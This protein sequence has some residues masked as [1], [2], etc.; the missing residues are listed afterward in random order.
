MPSTEGGA[1]VIMAEVQTSAAEDQEGA[2][3]LANKNGELGQSELP[4]KAVPEPT[5]HSST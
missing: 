5:V 3:P 1:D 4:T 2:S